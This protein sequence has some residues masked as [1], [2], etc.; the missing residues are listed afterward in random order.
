MLKYIIFLCSTINAGDIS[1]MDAVY[2]SIHATHPQIVKIHID[3]NLPAEEI[4]K[5]LK[6]AISKLNPNEVFVLAI[7]EK[8]I[9]GLK[10]VEDM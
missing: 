5:K 3:A 10:A 4:N 8:G 2:D 6:K 9:Y 7:G 1:H